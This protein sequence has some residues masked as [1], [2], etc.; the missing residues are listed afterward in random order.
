M[1]SSLRP[2]G[3]Y[4]PWNSPVQNTEVGSR[5]LL[6]DIFPAQ[7]LNP[8]LLHCRQIL[9]QLNYKGSRSLCLMSFLFHCSFIMPSFVLNRSPIQVWCMR[10]SAQG[11]CTGMTQRDGMGREV[12]GRIRVGTHVHPWLIH[13]NGLQ[14]PLQYCKVIGLRLK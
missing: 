12:G 7:G 14:K 8:G 13:V 10:Q 5:S 3:L 1:S 4:S 11:W 6:Q 2:H 9:Y